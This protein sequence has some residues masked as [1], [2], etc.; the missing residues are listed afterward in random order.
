MPSPSAGRGSE[1]GP[2]HRRAYA[3]N[4]G[5]PNACAL[6][7]YAA[8]R[9]G[10]CVRGSRTALQL[11]ELSLARGTFK[12]YGELFDHFA[13]YCAGEGLAP[14]PA[15]PWTVVAYVGYLLVAEQGTWAAESMQ[16]IFSAINRVHRD[17]G[18]L[19]PAVGNHFLS[20]VRRGLARA[21]V[22]LHS[23]DARIPVPAEAIL[24]IIA[25]GEAA[26]PTGA[27]NDPELRRLREAAAIALTALFAGR[28]R[29]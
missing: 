7:S 12:Q 27:V 22:A 19:P 11:L 13:D 24:A 16:P 18:E 26:R 6:E 4:L 2:T 20:A 9:I 8:A 28:R 15:D 14:V 5:E 29:Y 21:Q 3:L 17:M 23:R 1:C 10:A 25:D